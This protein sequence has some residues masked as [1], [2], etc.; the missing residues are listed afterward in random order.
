MSEQMKILIDT[1]IGDD[2][3]DAIAL[4]AAMRQNF[5]IVGITTVFENTIQRARQ[6]KKLLREYGHGYESVSVF[7]GYGTPIGER[8]R[9]VKDI[10]HYTPD[11]EQDIYAPSGTN[12]RDAVDF[13]IDACYKYGKELTVV[14]IGPFTNIA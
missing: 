6:V 7:A 3:D 11:L 10:P 5:E 4:Y 13:I 14:A 1:D 12:P 9:E 8:D 2:I